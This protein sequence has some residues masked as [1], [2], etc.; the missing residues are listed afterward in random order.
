MS[1]MT[2]EY[3]NTK[4]GQHDFK[5]KHIDD[6]LDSSHQDQKTSQRGYNVEI[7][8]SLLPEDQTFTA[9]TVGETAESAI[10][11]HENLVDLLICNKDIDN[12]ADSGIKAK[13]ECKINSPNIPK[14]L[15]HVPDITELYQL[16]AFT[17]FNIVMN[18]PKNAKF[19]DIDAEIE[20]IRDFLLK[21]F[22]YYKIDGKFDCD[23]EYHLPSGTIKKYIVSVTEKGIEIRS[24]ADAMLFY[25]EKEARV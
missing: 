20:Y 11:H 1:N 23:A 19:D 13:L 24:I 10:P 12:F 4:Y 2:I 21:T 18:D 15:G 6:N 3:L 17:E 25:F 8:T 9:R 16:D 7:S 14:D 22:D 5:I